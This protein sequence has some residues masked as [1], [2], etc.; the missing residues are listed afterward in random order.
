MQERCRQAIKKSYIKTQRVHSTALID[1]WAEQATTLL[2][3]LIAIPSLSR[4]E[5]AATTH[6]QKFLQARGA[7]VHRVKNNLWTCNK[8]FDPSKFTVLLNSHVDT[9]KANKDWTRD[10]H[11][12]DVVEGKIYGLGSNDAGASLVCYAMVF[13]HFMDRLDLP[14]NL[15]YA[16]T[17][18]EEISGADGIV[19]LL[20]ELPRI[21]AALVGEPTEMQMATAEKGLMV[22]R[23]T[24]L[25]RSGHAARN[26]G[27]NA[28]DI[29]MKD[30]AW[31][32]S[33]QFDKVSTALGPVKMT[34]TIINAG[35]QH[36]VVPDR[37]EF[38]VDV[39]TTDAYTNEQTLNIIEQHLS[40]QISDVS[41]R[42]QP[43]HI[44]EN[45]VLVRAARRLSMETYGSPTLSDQAL[46]SMPS[47]KIGPGS[48]SRS[49]T[50]DEFVYE[51]EIR[52]G[53]AGLIRLVTTVMELLNNGNEE[54]ED[55]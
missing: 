44:S 35:T 16:P 15:I 38:T 37:C 1:H 32:H 47:V 13:L 24:A 39:R 14:F 49:H 9:V 20:P 33:Y 8:V 31:L 11:G 12:A 29:A 28:I 55:A 34:T 46:L 23:C 10:P 4:E 30:I 50:A 40:S 52:G 18:E 22:L 36:N 54:G 43:S 48:S 7:T 19:A 45:H 27:L 2:R 53:V 17:A 51:Q 6:L 3:E 21:D 25:G 26:E 41:K 42:L 5:D